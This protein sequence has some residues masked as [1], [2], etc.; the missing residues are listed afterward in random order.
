MANVIQQ[1]FG[2]AAPA[3]DSLAKGEL[4]IR[5]V[6]ANHTASSSSKLYFGEGDSANLRQF[7]FGIT[8]GS[9]Q[10]GVAIGETLTFAASGDATVSVSGQT[11]TI[12]ASGSGSAT[13]INNNADNRIIT[14]SGTSN[15]LNGEANLTFDGTDLTVASSGKVIFGDANSYIFQSSENFYI[16]GHNDMY[17]NIDTPNDSTARHFIWRANTSNELMRLGE[18][19]RLE[20]QGDLYLDSDGAVIHFGDDANTSFTH[21]NNTGFRINLSRQLQFGDS[22]TYIHQSADGVLDLVSDNEIE[23]N[24]TTID[25]NGAADISGNL[26][27]GGN[28]TV[29]GSISASGDIGGQ[30]DI[31]INDDCIFKD[32]VSLDSDAAVL[33]FGDDAEVNLTH[34]HDTGLLLNSTNQLQ[35]GD[36]G[37]YIHQSADGVLDLV[38]DSEIEINATTIDMNGAV[39]VSGNLTIGGNIVAAG[40]ITA[41]VGGEITLD[42][43]SGNIRLKDGGTQFGMIRNGTSNLV[44]ENTTQDKDINFK[45]N[46]GGSTITAL[47]LDMSAGGTATFSNSVHVGGNISLPEAGAIFFDSTDTS[48]TTNTEDPEDLFIAA[49]Q[50]LFLRPDN[51]VLIQ[52]GTTSYAI[53]DGAN[54]RVGIGN[55]SP[56]VA[57]DVTGA[58]AVSSNATIGGYVDAVNFKIN[59]SQGSDGQ[60]LTSTGSGVA[61]E[62]V[63]SSGGT[64]DTTGTVNADEFPQFTDSNTLQALTATQMR[65]A[66]NVANGADNYGQWNVAITTNEGTTSTG[67]I[68]SG[69]TAKWAAG[70][71]L[72]IEKSGATITYSAED[73]TSS[74]K[75][76]ASFSSDD[77]SVSSGAVTIKSSGVTNAQLA[78]SIANSKLANSTISGV[79]LGS[80]MGLND[81]S[82]ATFSSGVLTIDDGSNATQIDSG[83]QELKIVS[84]HGG[85]S[86]ITLDAGGDIILDPDEEE[87]IIKHAGTEKMKIITG[88]STT[89]SGQHVKFQT[90]PTGNA[91]T[92]LIEFDTLSGLNLTAEGNSQST[93]RLRPTAHGFAGQLFSQSNIQYYH[94]TSDTVTV[95]RSSD[96]NNNVYY[97]PCLSCHSIMAKDDTIEH[98]F[99]APCNGLLLAVIMTSNNPL[100]KDE[101]GNSQFTNMQL[102]ESDSSGANPFG[103]TVSGSTTRVAGLDA[104]GNSTGTTEITAQQESGAGA[105]VAEAIFNF[106]ANGRFILTKGKTYGF[107]WRMS[108]CPQATKSH[109]LNIHYIIAW[110]EVSTDSSY[111]GWT[112]Y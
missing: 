54:Q 38:A 75:G 61:W 19:K 3:S 41:D 110:D 6:A 1:K 18:D 65:S 67:G 16:R 77:F 87:I 95:D 78:G 58:F 100:F 33:R 31:I 93:V 30:D 13:T 98:S 74:N 103:G 68:Q 97:L 56:S 52:A 73:A 24:A 105:D 23:L 83:N 7:G 11:V 79:A 12:G 8:D 59:G 80:N 28:I 82:D 107:G 76:V 46:D 34:V 71:G 51:D 84:A 48:I 101:G 4:A 22:G 39:D 106:A 85:S 53:F 42:T 5:F 36:S 44:I 14:G 104:D 96:V 99:Q 45:G 88:D 2:T 9:T 29:V 112:G 37:T 89:S 60:V 27:V 64:V 32:N 70:E 86:H 43:D 26:A 57:L 92:S 21:I 35:F 10:S 108:D 111:S 62:S 17:F 50:D 66:L 109:N 55:T 72:D 20:L 49:D 69:G 47:S 102:F 81:L 25:M 94:S 63:S 40:D 90:P 91:N 15:T